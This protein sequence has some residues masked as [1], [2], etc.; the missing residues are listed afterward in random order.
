[1]RTVWLRPSA[2]LFFFS[3]PLS[4]HKVHGQHSIAHLTP[5]MRRQYLARNIMHRQSHQSL[6][7]RTLTTAQ[8]PASRDRTACQRRVG[9][10]DD[11]ERQ[12]GGKR[13]GGLGVRKQTIRNCEACARHPPGGARGD[14]SFEL[15]KRDR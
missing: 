8:A 3:S 12:S 2:S 14:F 1:M 11:T 5:A 13:Q 9:R 4:L 7:C 15:L 10:H 6:Q